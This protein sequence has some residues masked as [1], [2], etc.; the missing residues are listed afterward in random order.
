MLS[1]FTTENKNRET[2][3]SFGSPWIYLVPWLWWLHAGCLHYVRIHQIVHIKYV[4]LC[5]YQLYLSYAMKQKTKCYWMHSF[6]THVTDEQD[7]KKNSIKK[8][9]LKAITVY[10]CDLLPVNNSTGITKVM[11]S[12]QVGIH[13][14]CISS[15][16]DVFVLVVV[17]VCFFFLLIIVHLAG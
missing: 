11:P 15:S 6:Q 8:Q 7:N 9:S 4:Q 2:Q 17:V 14:L 3:G 16:G 13:N 1:V 12:I 10:S 5:V